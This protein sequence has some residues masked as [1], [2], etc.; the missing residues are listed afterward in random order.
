MDDDLPAKLA[1]FAGKGYVIAPAGYGKTHLIA[2][3]VKA[4]SQ[5][6]LILTHTY[7]GVN[8]IK[9]K[10]QTLAVPASRYQIDTIASWTLRLCLYFPNTSKW[11]K[12]Y[13]SGKEWAKLYEA[14]TALLAKPFVE[15]FVRS[16][17]SGVY[18]DEYQDCS[19]QQH[20]LV[21]AIGKHLSCRLLG[22]P[23]QAIFDFADKPVDWERDVYPHY[24]LLG[25]LKKPWRWH[26][27]G[28]PELG[29]WLDE[30]S[31]R[32]RAGEKISITTPLPKG[33]NRVAVDLAD[34]TNPKRLNCFFSFLDTDDAVIAI[35]SG[36]QKSKNKT[37]KLAQ[38]LGGRF[39]SIEEVEGKDIFSFIKK[40]EAAK[41]VSERLC[42]IIEFAKKCCNAVDGI[43]SAATK[44]GEPARATKA[45]KYPDILELANRY[46]VDPSSPNLAHL[47]TAIQSNPDT[48]TYRRDLLNRFMKVLRVH[49]ENSALSLQESAQR[50]Q[51]DFRHSGRP[52]RHNKLIGTTLLVKGL[53]YDHAIILEAESMSPKELYV[54]LTRGAK[55]I[56]IVSLRD[57][58][59]T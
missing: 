39:S 55:T 3:A 5:R 34:F 17:Y 37:H 52:I 29:G 18:V 1:A 42:L 48:S 6:Q 31:K 41:T 54:A 30:A 9:K 11:N 35:H 45:T 7:A 57:A 16:S 25:E 24:Q 36:D 22:D 15:R 56:T 49:E 26:S 53:E 38:A 4:S 33:V 19:S 46:L 40:L 23:M 12:E 27:A 10:M 2:M 44:R 20:T 43:L 32:L 21:E 14:G 28:A 8:A 59:P 47:L 13:P 51:R 50:Y 58:I